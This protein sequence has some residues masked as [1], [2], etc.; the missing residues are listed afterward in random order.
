[1]SKK[2]VASL[3]AFVGVVLFVLHAL[4]IADDVQAIIEDPN[5][6]NKPGEILKLAVDFTRYFG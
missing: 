1:M 2:D 5:K 6:A 4:T 3:V